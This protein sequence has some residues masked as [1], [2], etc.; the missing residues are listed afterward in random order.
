MPHVDDDP[1][2]DPEDL[3]ELDKTV[4]EVYLSEKILPKRIIRIG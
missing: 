4:T 2:T 1:D 3:L